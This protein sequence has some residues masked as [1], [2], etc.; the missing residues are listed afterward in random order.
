M[1]AMIS[2]LIDEAIRDISYTKDAIDFIEKY[3]YGMF[4]F[5]APGTERYKLYQ[6]SQKAVIVQ[7]LQKL[8]RLIIYDSSKVQETTNKQ[9][10]ILQLSA[11]YIGQISYLQKEGNLVAILCDPAR[12]K[13]DVKEICGAFFINHYAEELNSTISNWISEGRF[14]LVKHSS[15]ITPTTETPLPNKELCSRYK[16]VLDR[17]SYGKADKKSDYI[18]VASEV[19]RR[20]MYSEDLR[21]EA[22]NKNKG[23]MRRIFSFNNNGTQYVS[24]DMENGTLEAHNKKGKHLGEYNYE[25]VQTEP[26]DKSGNHDITV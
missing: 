21:V 5:F 17:V 12:F 7:K 1:N 23:Q 8:R 11:E 18:A 26:P 3:M 14:D 19:A 2:F 25:G 6:R 9:Y 4:V 16:S 15:L 10:D 22:K 13:T 20:N 24:I